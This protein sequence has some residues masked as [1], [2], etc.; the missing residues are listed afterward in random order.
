MVKD[1][2]KAGRCPHCDSSTVVMDGSPD[3][4]FTDGNDAALSA[5]M[6]CEKCGK[7]WTEVYLFDHIEEV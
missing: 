7:V 4:G 3:F 5:P 1:K 6:K 2:P